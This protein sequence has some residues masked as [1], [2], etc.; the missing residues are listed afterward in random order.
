MR[1]VGLR[2]YSGDVFFRL[3][4]ILKKK[5]I[6]PWKDDANPK[7]KHRLKDGTLIIKI[8]S[9]WEYLRYL[10]YAKTMTIE[11]SLAKILTERKNK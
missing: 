10:K 8:L 5:N 1:T 3:N 4:Q 9:K 2:Y 7:I 6:M 11:D